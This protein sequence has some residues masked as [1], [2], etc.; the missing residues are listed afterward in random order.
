MRRA[1]RTLGRPAHH[2]HAQ[3]LERRPLGPGMW[4][5]G[6]H[7]ST[8]SLEEAN[9][10]DLYLYITSLP[11]FFTTRARRQLAEKGRS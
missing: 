11:Q 4:H 6:S 2:K 5:K 7:M 9:S 3:T 1:V 10:E 8:T